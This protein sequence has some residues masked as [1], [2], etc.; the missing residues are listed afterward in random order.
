MPSFKQS[1]RVG[2][3]GESARAVKSLK[4]YVD[5]NDKFRIVTSTTRP[6]KFLTVG[7][8]IYETDTAK[9]LV[10]QGATTGWTPPWNTAWGDVSTT[11]TAAVQA[12][13][14]V[15]YA[16]V[17]GL[18]VT[19]TALKNRKYEIEADVVFRKQ[20][21]AG[22]VYL[23]IHTGAAVVKEAISHLAAID[24][25][26]PLRVGHSI[27][28][29]ATAAVTWKIQAKA[30]TAGGNLTEAATWIARLKVIDVGSTGLPA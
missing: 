7:D 16:D 30:S 3:D 22:Y 14:A 28:A 4:V 19:F 26:G 6:T 24:A 1:D 17:T 20:T 8:T 13:L 15:A 21:T 2:V 9:T 5:Q 18:T 11:S 27:T 23:G 12:G 10:Y 29:A 25:Y